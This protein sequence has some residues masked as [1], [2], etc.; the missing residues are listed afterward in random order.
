MNINSSLISEMKDK[1]YRDAYVASQ[2]R[3]GMPFQ[4]RALRKS[5]NW[6]QSQLAERAGMSQPRISEI[7]KPG[8][9]SLNVDTALRIAAACDVGL[10]VRFVPFS[11]LIEWS[12]TLDIEA[13]EDS[14]NVSIPSFE[15]EL[16]R[17]EAKGAL[18]AFRSFLGNAP[19]G[20]VVSGEVFGKLLATRDNQRENEGIGKMVSH[21]GDNEDIRRY[22]G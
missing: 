15:A 2:I 3:I 1:R 19:D 18:E 14:N 10:Q 20:N 9:R 12:E 13:L 7:E 6:S 17:E 21:G 8:A 22:F 11:E 5:R 16:E 4:V